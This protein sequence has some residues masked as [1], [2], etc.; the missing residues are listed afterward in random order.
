MRNIGK[1]IGSQDATK[2][3]ETKYFDWQVQTAR[4]WAQEKKL[5]SKISQFG[6]DDAP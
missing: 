4:E 5:E 6:Q 2:R 1:A 3:I